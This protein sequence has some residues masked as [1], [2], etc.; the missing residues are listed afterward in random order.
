[1]EKLAT[2]AEDEQMSVG[3]PF[4]VVHRRPSARRGRGQT[5][6]GHIYLGDEFTEKHSITLF[7]CSLM[8]NSEKLTTVCLKDKWLNFWKRHPTD[9]RLAFIREVKICRKDDAHTHK[10]RQQRSLYPEVQEKIHLELDSALG[11]DSEGPLSV[12]VLNE[13]KY[14]HPKECGSQ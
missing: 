11:T 12:A 14:L 4:E 3:C 1:M 13:L 9:K 6:S 2:I 10:R 7:A 8:Q 5:R